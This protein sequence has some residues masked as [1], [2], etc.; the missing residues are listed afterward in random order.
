MTLY[1]NVSAAIMVGLLVLIAGLHRKSIAKAESRA[2]VNSELIAALPEAIVVFDQ[3]GCI[4]MV[5][6]TAGQL[7]GTPADKLLGVPFESLFARE[8]DRKRAGSLHGLSGLRAGRLD[9]SELWAKQADQA[10]LPLQVR[11][12]C[13]EQDGRTCFLASLRDLSSQQQVKSALHRYIEQLVAT[14]DALRK[15]NE[16]LEC[17]VRDRTEALSIAKCAAENANGAKSEFLANMSHELRTPLHA[18]LSFS[19]FGMRRYETDERTKLLTYFERIQSTGQT[20][21]GLLNQLLDL[22]KLE[23]GSVTMESR[24]LHLIPLMRGVC[25]EFAAL[26]REKQI[27]LRVDSQSSDDVV[28]GDDEKLSQVIRNLLGNALK[29]SP[30]GGAVSLELSASQDVLTVYVRDSGPGIPDDEC[31]VVFEKFVQSQTTKNGAGG[32]GLGLAICREIVTRHN[33]TIVAEPTNGRGASIR[34][35]LPRFSAVVPEE[36]A[37][38]VIANSS[39]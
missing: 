36:Q 37:S 25:D 2:R 24:P 15:H 23:S 10:A 8:V 13:I 34:V 3:G 5:N 14:K 16:I 11:T 12:R 39:A 18:I 33:G 4:Q 28:V 19:R 17:L 31:A 22:A 7:I 20:L 30:T 26:A 27:T 38:A 9:A 21:L 6:K 32:T 35:E 29:F 1:D